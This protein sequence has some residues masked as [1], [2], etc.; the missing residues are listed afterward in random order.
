MKAFRGGSSNAALAGPANASPAPATGL[1]HT[2]LIQPH[3]LAPGC[4]HP[5]RLARDASTDVR[6]GRRDQRR[7]GGGLC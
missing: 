2:S 7:R 4:G 6:G 3:R 1:A 5:H